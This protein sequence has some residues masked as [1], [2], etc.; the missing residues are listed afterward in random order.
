MPSDACTGRHKRSRLL[1]SSPAPF[2][3]QATASATAGLFFRDDHRF[4]KGQQRDQL[5]KSFY[6]ELRR[7]LL[8]V[9]S[10]LIRFFEERP[11]EFFNH[12]EFLN[13][14]SVRCHG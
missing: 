4:R 5:S 11:I 12:K 8:G 13:G 10:N 1:A 3:A 14:A 7:S 6:N 2:L 9:G